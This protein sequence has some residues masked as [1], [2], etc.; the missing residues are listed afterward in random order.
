MAW[1]L[2]KVRD[3][4]TFMPDNFRAKI[5]RGLLEN[6]LSYEVGFTY[7]FLYMKFSLDEVLFHSKN[8]R[9]PSVLC[10]INCTFPR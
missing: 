2:V 3:K 1:Y 4:F 7:R 5:T 10:F 8:C 6:Y 9:Q